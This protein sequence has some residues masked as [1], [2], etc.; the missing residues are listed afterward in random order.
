MH[1]PPWCNFRLTNNHSD[2]VG[3]WSN[4][5]RAPSTIGRL[6][7][8][9]SSAV[10]GNLI[11]GALFI[12]MAAHLGNHWK[13]HIFT[14]RGPGTGLAH[15]IESTRYHREKEETLI[16]TPDSDRSVCDVGPSRPTCEPT[17]EYES[18]FPRIKTAGSDTYANDDRAAPP[19]ALR[20]SKTRLPYQ[21]QCF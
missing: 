5:R 14:T 1:F 15:A 17:P 10:W 2:L 20:R 12:G 21:R 11:G 9:Q 16:P 18:K 19:P 4:V 6:R 7:Y 8:C 13:Y 3:C